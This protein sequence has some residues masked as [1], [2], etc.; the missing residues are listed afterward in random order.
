MKIA[1]GVS[2]LRVKKPLKWAAKVC[3]SRKILND[4]QKIAL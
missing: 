3:E 2:K 1:L 4:P